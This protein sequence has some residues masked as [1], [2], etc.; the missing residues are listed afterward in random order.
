MVAP[1][2][3]HARLARAA[4]TLVAKIRG[5]GGSVC[6]AVDAI[7]DALKMENDFPI[8]CAVSDLAWFRPDLIDPASPVPS[9]IGSA[10]YMD[11]LQRHLKCSNHDQVSQRVMARSPSCGP[12]RGDRCSRSTSSTWR[13]SSA[14]TTRMSSAPRTSRA[15]TDSRPEWT[16]GSPSTSTARPQRRR[17]AAS[18][19]STSLRAAR[20][21]ASRRCAR[22]SVRRGMR[23]KPRSRRRSSTRASPPAAPPTRSAATRSRGRRAT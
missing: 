22:R 1:R 14:S 2:V 6:A 23:P 13:A 3:R 19:Q 16:R 15:R 17:Q 11:L 9:G 10:P 12:R 4:P 8:F 20:A 21:P 5:A 7:N 18:R